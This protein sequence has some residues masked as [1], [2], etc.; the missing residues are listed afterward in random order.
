MEA[1]VHEGDVGVHG[2]V[3]ELSGLPDPSGHRGH[4]IE[5]RDVRPRTVFPVLPHV[6]PL[7]NSA[8]TALKENA[9][10]GDVTGTPETEHTPTNPTAIGSGGRQQRTQ[11]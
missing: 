7:H 8:D 3:A 4:Q 1:E 11:G 6:Y 5:H 9:T 10:R 2:P